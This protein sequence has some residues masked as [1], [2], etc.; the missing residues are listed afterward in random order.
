MMVFTAMEIKALDLEHVELVTLSAC[1]TGIGMRTD[2]EGMLSLQRAVTTGRSTQFVV[3]HVGRP[4]ALATNQL[5]AD[6][7]Y[8]LWNKKLSRI[9]SFRQA[10]LK[11][12]RQAP[13]IG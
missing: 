13:T 2:G 10:Q 9:E 12:F 7:Y 11:M 6:F 4:D 3:Q 1:Q 5:M 8:N